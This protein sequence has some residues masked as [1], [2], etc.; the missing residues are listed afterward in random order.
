MQMK[1]LRKIK[2]EGPTWFVA[3]AIYAGWILMTL[4][5]HHIPALL[6]PILGGILVCWHGSLQHETIHGHP[7]R[8]DWLNSLIGFWPLGFITPYC[9]YRETHLEH[10]QTEELANPEADP[11]SYY[12]TRKQWEG[13]P[14]WMQSL[15]AIN[16]HLIGR[17]VLGPFLYTFRFWQL[18]FQRFMSWDYGRPKRWMMHGL[19]VAGLC[20]WI[21]VICGMPIWVYVLAFVYPGT[22]LSLLRS[23]FEHRKE[24]E[25]KERSVIVESNFFFRWL[26]LNNNFHII[27]HMYPKL[28]W[29]EI[30]PLYQRQPEYYQKLNGDFVFSGYGEIF[31]R[32]GGKVKDLPLYD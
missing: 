13:L 7:T 15:F 30:Y 19:A 31:R 29:S 24:G 20:Y 22:S 14:G 8:W 23:F 12:W 4:N 2:Q 10:H 21:V 16:N 1:R 32:Y 11:E 28:A 5:H 18:E 6:L 9:I 27:H 26:Y 25:Q 17:L 3:L